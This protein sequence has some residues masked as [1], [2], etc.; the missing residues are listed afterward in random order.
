MRVDQPYES[1]EV[2]KDILYRCRDRLTRGGHYLIP[3]SSYWW[4]AFSQH[5][6][7]LPIVYAGLSFGWGGGL[8]AAVSSCA[9]YSPHIFMAS[10]DSAISATQFSE[11]L[12]FLVVGIGSGIFL[13]RERRSEIQLS[14]TAEDPEKVNR[15]PQE[16]FEAEMLRDEKV[17]FASVF[18]HIDMH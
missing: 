2:E 15:G 6:Y 5:L 14:Q 17:V 12:I 10:L 13:D 9:A 4:H 16:S 8:L 18:Q 11:V 3:M 7:L 1:T